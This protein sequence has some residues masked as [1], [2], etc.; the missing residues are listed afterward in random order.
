MSTLTNENAVI[1]NIIVFPDRKDDYIEMGLAK[2][3]ASDHD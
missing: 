1:G 3:K 2:I